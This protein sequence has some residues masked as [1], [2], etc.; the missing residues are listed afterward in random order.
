MP[1]PRLLGDILAGYHPL[2]ASWYR[3]V[4]GH[5]RGC[6][7]NLQRETSLSRV[8]GP[9]GHV[10]DSKLVFALLMA[11]FGAPHP[12]VFGF[13]QDGRWHW[14]DG[15]RE[16][17]DAVFA[18]GGRAVLKPTYG[19]KGRAISFIDGPDGLD[20]PAGTEMLVTAFVAQAD[21]AATIFA[22]SLNTIRVLTVRS[23]GGEAQV[24]AAVHRFGGG[25]TRGVD[26]FSQGGVVASVDLG[27]GTLDRTA[28]IGAG[29]RLVWS[30]H[31]PDSGAPVRGVQVTGWEGVKALALD[32][33][34]RLPFLRY[35]G[36]DIA[37]AR[38]GRPLVIEG[39]AHPSLRFFQFYR[40]ILDE[41]ATRE[42]FLERLRG[43]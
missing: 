22:G 7:S 5:S 1:I 17:L 29:N 36:W 41:P 43:H 38:D 13:T 2:E 20:V 3:Q 6:V 12:R 15:G 11:R 14:L 25:S 16:A 10:L 27:T 28:S 39:N 30:D 32:L 35:V 42:F 4:R 31:H 8:N 34:A 18:G 26:N 33:C 24:A 23:R 21:Y 40:P 19:G 37:V 9:D